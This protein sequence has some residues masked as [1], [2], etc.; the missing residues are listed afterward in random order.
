MTEPAVFSVML[1]SNLPYACNDIDVI[2]IVFS[3]FSLIGQE[4]SKIFG[5]VYERLFF[6]LFRRCTVCTSSTVEFHFRFST[7]A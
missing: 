6:R 1:V 2:M 4:E 7:N 3:C 5:Y